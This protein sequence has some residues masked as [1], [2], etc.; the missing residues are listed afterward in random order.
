MQ[1]VVDFL[2]KYVQWIAL[3][4]GALY[5]GFMAYSYLVQP[6]ITVPDAKGT[7]VLPGDVDPGIAKSVQNLKTAMSDK[8][9]VPYPPFDWQPG[10]KGPLVGPAVVLKPPRPDVPPTPPT[11]PTTPTPRRNNVL[12]VV[13]PPVAPVDSTV[14]RVTVSYAN[15]NAVPAAP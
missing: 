12:A 3:G 5:L 10:I 7:A 9:D 14:D 8:T 11:T 15:P 13:P 2:E 1:K 6:A 4:I